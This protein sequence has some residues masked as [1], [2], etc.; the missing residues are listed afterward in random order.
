MPVDKYPTFNFVGRIVGPRGRTIK[1]IE[2]KTGVKILVRGRGSV[3]D[4]GLV[5]TNKPNY[6]HLKEPLHVILQVE[7]TEDR[8]ALRLAAAEE[9]IVKLTNPEF[10][11][12]RDEIKRKQLTELAILNGTYSP[13]GCPKTVQSSNI[14]TVHIP[15]NTGAMNQYPIEQSVIPQA[16]MI[17]NGNLVLANPGQF[18]QP[19]ILYPT[20]ENGHQA[21][22]VYYLQ[23]Q[24]MS[25]P[26][27]G[28]EYVQQVN[29]VIQSQGGKIASSKTTAKRSAPY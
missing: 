22:P 11:D 17:Q 3:R 24:F 20:A 27:I 1:E 15:Q 7:D 6:E 14:P 19:Q 25:Q 5:L 8:V 23:N 4:E 13:S 29:T 2:R 26:N 16:A 12:G 18:F 28:T 9:E 21:T 10:E